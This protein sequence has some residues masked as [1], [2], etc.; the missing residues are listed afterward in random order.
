VENIGCLLR[1]HL[2]TYRA[3][4]VPGLSN[5]MV[6]NIRAALASVKTF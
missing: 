2:V 1:N 6:T 5:R 4:L 3:F